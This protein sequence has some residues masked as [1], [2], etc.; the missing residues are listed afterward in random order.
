MWKLND[1][2]TREKFEQCVRTKCQ[3]LPTVVEPAWEVIKTGLLEAAD[4]TCGWTKGGRQRYKETWWWNEFVDN[5]IKKRKAWKSW[6][7]GGDMEVYLAAK[8]AAK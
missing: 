7:S 3:D 8:R 1:A 2:E 4:E 6:K 5:T